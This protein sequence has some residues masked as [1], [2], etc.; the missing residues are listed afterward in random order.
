MQ[1]RHRQTKAEH[2]IVL[3]GHKYHAAVMLTKHALMTWIGKTQARAFNKWC[4]V[5]THEFHTKSE[6]GTALSS[7]LQV[8]LQA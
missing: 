2:S 3:I 6:R 4:G 7:V 5:V 8:G 1:E